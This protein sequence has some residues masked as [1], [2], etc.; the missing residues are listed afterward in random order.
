MQGKIN[1]V[2]AKIKKVSLDCVP[3]HC[4]IHREALVAKRIKGIDNNN[5]SAIFENFL[6]E[7]VNVVNY[8]RERS[9]KHR[10][11]MKLCEE[12]E[13]SYKRLLFHSEVRWLSRG[14]VLSRVFELRKEF[15]TFFW[16]KRVNKPLNFLIIFG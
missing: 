12:M 16:R 2:V 15:G 10:M 9:K 7:I 4:V 11:F 3:I 13:A 1:G 14:R 8:I 5:A 6:N